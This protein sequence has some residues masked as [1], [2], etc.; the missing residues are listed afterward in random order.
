M[1]YSALRDLSDDPK[2]AESLGNMVIAWAYAEETLI[3]VLA[4]VSGM[5]LNMALDGYY[6]I[7]TFES[8][9]KFI[10]SLFY[11]WQAPGNIDKS[12][13]DTEI[14]KLSHLSSTRNHWVH[15]NWCGDDAT[16]GIIIFDHRA[17]IDS[18][19][20][21]KPVKAADIRNHIQA[22]LLRANK[23]RSLINWGS[24]KL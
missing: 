3:G 18:P 9:V 7:P 6:R 1:T 14:D 8:R 5:G 15:G 19:H 21:S 12:V 11:E 2:L 4:C 10:R 17:P 13:L 20:R 23:L 24:L 16:K 22:V